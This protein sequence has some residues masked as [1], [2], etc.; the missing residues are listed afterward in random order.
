MHHAPSLSRIFRFWL[1]LAATWLMMSVEGPLLAALIARLSE[2]KYNLAAYGVAFSF[3]MIVEAPIIMIMSASAAL[4][5]DA[6]SFKRLRIFT[7]VLNG[8][9][10]GI[11]LLLLVPSVFGWLLGDLIGLPGNVREL[12]YYSLVFLL[13]WPGAIGYRR[14]YHGILIRVDKTRLVALGTIV[15]LSSM[16]GV[17]FGLYHWGNIQGAYLGAIAL[18][19]AVVI[20]ALVSRAMAHRAVEKLLQEEATEPV[21]SYWEITRFYYPLA[22]TSMLALATHPMVT[23]FMGRSR[24][25]IESLAVLPVV[26]SLVFVFRSFGLAFQEVGIVLIG[27]QFQGYRQLRKFAVGLM[28]VTTGGLFLIAF[29]PLNSS[30]FQAMSGL[31]PDLTSL[32]GMTTRIL[33]FIPGLTVLLCFQRAMAINLRKTH[34]VTVATGIEVATIVS[35]LAIL[36]RAGWV[37]AIAAACAMMAGRL[38]ANSYLAIRLSPRLKSRVAGLGSQASPLPRLRQLLTKIIHAFS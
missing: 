18:S 22:L 13:P 21:P 14:L 5:R 27:A 8:I 32:A 30:W 24:S 1:P 11:M 3:A 36:T 15:R 23:F 19:T 2:P 35:L 7:Y 20:E 38:G 31:D 6:E 17:A 33:A 29:T 16:A 12:V 4:A 34:F 28:M 25:P 9:T 37:G 10:T 26:N